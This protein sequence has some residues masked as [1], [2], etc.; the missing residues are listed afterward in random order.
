MHI[1]DVGFGNSHTKLGVFLIH[2]HVGFKFGVQIFRV[3]LMLVHVSSKKMC[4]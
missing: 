2:A 4:L 3:T 1:T